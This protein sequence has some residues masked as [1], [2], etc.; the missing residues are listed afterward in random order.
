MSKNYYEVEIVGIGGFGNYRLKRSLML[1][2]ANNCEEAKATIQQRGYSVF[3]VNGI[4]ERTN[5]YE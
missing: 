5:A 2:K 3:C 4:A 1:V